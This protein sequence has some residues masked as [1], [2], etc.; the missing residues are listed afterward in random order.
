MLK[1]LITLSTA[2]LLASCSGNK[3]LQLSE[4]D[5]ASSDWSGTALMFHY[6]LTA[7]DFKSIEGGCKLTLVN[8]MTDGSYS[9]ELHPGSQDAIVLAPV[10]AYR[11]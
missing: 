3:V 1:H 5:L 4:V 10:G 11:A 7:N 2:L 8:E 9:L 6:S